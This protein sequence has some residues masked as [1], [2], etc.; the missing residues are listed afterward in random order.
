MKTQWNDE[1]CQYCKKYITTITEREREMLL[2]MNKIGVQIAIS[3]EGQTQL[4]EIYTC[5]IIK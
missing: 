2:Q 5:I 1:G 3:I 4:T